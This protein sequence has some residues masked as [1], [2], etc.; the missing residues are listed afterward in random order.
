MNGPQH[1]LEAERLLRV[2]ESAGLDES[3][4]IAVEAQAHATMALV[5]LL[6]LAM[7]TINPEDG[8]LGLTV[9]TYGDW[10]EAVDPVETP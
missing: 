7:P 8:G 6:A 3:P 4:A 10:A 2:A 1:Y 9:E 5:A